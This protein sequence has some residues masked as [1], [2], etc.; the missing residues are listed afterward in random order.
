MTKLYKSGA[1]KHGT[2]EDFMSTKNPRYK[3][4]FKSSTAEI[5]NLLATQKDK[6]VSS[7]INELILEALDHR[8][9]LVLS[10]IAK[11]RDIQKQKTIVHH[12]A[13]K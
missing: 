13:W 10:T 6:S 7:I 2:K 8:E 4:I 11:I 3:I 12:D 9:D 5:L 1:L